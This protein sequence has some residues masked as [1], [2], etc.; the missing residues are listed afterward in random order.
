M[1]IERKKQLLILAETLA[2][3]IDS[4]NCGNFTPKIINAIKIA[5]EGNILGSDFNAKFMNALKLLEKSAFGGNDEERG[6]KDFI[7]TS[8]KSR[9]FSE[10]NR[11]SE[12]ELS[13]VFYWTR[14]IVKEKK[15]RLKEERKIDKDTSFNDNRNKKSNI[16]KNHKY[17]TKYEEKDN[18]QDNPF[19]V[20]KNFVK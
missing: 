3:E 11:L 19:S 17:S 8:L 6:Y 12:D 4:K 9:Q 13:F 14:R 2:K 5:K 15:S 18:N 1:N 16:G 7:N 10:I 20:L